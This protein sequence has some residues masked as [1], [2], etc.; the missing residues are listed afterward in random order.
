MTPSE[1]AW[2]KVED[3]IE[4][5]E[6]S[7]DRLL[8]AAEKKLIDKLVNAMY[9][10]QRDQNVQTRKD[11]TQ[12]VDDVIDE[13]QEKELKPIVEAIA[14]DIVQTV[15][16]I[17]DYFRLQIQSANFLTFSKKVEKDLLGKMGIELTEKSFKIVLGGYLDSLT[18]NP[19]IRNGIQKIIV[20]SVFNSSAFADMM[21]Q[22]IKYVQGTDMQEGKLQKHFKTMAIDT[23]NIA[24]RSQEDIIAEKFTMDS[25]LFTGTVIDTT[26]CFCK[27]RAGKVILVKEA[28][29]DWPDLRNEAC[30]PRWDDSLKYEPLKHMGGHRCRHHKRYITNQE[31]MRRDKTLKVDESGNLYRAV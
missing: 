29:N 10:Y 26:R 2:K 1:K 3:L 27:E 14:K 4:Q 30:G 23:F 18:R 17:N 13:F 19:E 11:L 28:V 20:D 8:S 9:D 12:V 15:K 5:V 22:L 24:A 7:S 31:A 16:A 21:K 6:K 25:F